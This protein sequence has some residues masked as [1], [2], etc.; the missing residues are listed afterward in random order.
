MRTPMFRKG[1]RVRV[2][3][4]HR[5]SPATV[6]A[7]TVEQDQYLLREVWVRLDTDRRIYC[8]TS[9]RVSMAKRAAAD[10][11]ALDI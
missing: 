8:F 3:I 1:D 9:D 5:G 4:P 7:G 11:K 2:V 6:E 10:Q